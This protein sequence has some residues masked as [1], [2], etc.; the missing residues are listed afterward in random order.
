VDVVLERGGPQ[1]V[2]IEVKA[3]ATVTAADVPDH[4][5]SLFSREVLNLLAHREI[6]LPVSDPRFHVMIASS[7]QAGEPLSRGSRASGPWTC[8]SCGRD[9]PAP[10]AC[11][12]DRR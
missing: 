8:P 1:V 4:E 6:S 9:L 5:R 12:S 11:E 2:G 10:P 7:R 3:A